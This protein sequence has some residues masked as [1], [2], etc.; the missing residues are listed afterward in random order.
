MPRGSP[1]AKQHTT[2]PD[3][4]FATALTR[5]ARRVDLLHLV[6]WHWPLYTAAV[7]FY[8]ASIGVLLARDPSPSYSA[9][10]A[11]V[12]VCALVCS[13]AFKYCGG[14][15]QHKAVDLKDWAAYLQVRLQR[16]PALLSQLK[17]PLFWFAATVVLGEV[18]K[19][20]PLIPF[21]V[22]AFLVAAAAFGVMR[23]ARILHFME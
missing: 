9:H 15:I 3:A 19:V 11:C 1:P 17:R 20:L 22:V 6:R 23:L 16:H 8:T 12:L 7:V 10:V 5:C 13:L 14:V 2:S 18:G 21:L 4:G